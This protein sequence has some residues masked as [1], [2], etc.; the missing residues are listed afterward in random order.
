MPAHD[1]LAKEP[2]V[3]TQ[4]P[5][6]LVGW[7]LHG[8]GGRSLADAGLVVASRTPSARALAGSWQG[9][10]RGVVVVPSKDLAGGLVGFLGKDLGKV[11]RLLTLI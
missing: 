8:N 4:V 2:F 5:V 10:C 9:S 6:R 11:R 1:E 3:D 7:Q